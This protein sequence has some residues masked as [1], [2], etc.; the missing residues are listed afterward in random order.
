MLSRDLG[1]DSDLREGFYR[2][3]KSAIKL[4]Q[5]SFGRFPNKSVALPAYLALRPQH[6]RQLAV[7]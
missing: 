4:L 1:D 2:V 7:S 6:D 3:P 5:S